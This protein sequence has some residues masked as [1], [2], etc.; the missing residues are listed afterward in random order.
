MTYFSGTREACFGR[1]AAER[2]LCS[3]TQEL[4][5]DWNQ[6]EKSGDVV[7]EPLVHQVALKCWILLNQT[8]INSASFLL[9]KN[10]SRIWVS[11]NTIEK[12]LLTSGF[13]SRGSR[14]I[15][16]TPLTETQIMQ[17]NL[18][19]LAF[20]FGKK[21]RH[22]PDEEKICRGDKTG[23]PFF[24]MNAAWTRLYKII[25]Q[26]KMKFTLMFKEA[27]I[28]RAQRILDELFKKQPWLTEQNCRKY[29]P[30]LMMAIL[31]L[32]VKASD[33][34]DNECSLINFNCLILN[35]RDSSDPSYK[36]Y[37]CITT[38]DLVRMESFLLSA[39]D[40]QVPTRIP[41]AEDIEAALFCKS[42]TANELISDL[43]LLDPGNYAIA[44]ELDH[45]ILVLR[46][47][48]NV[49]V[50]RFALAAD[51]GDI[52]FPLSTATPQQRYGDFLLF[53][54]AVCAAH[55]VENNTSPSP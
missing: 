18:E 35:R 24:E 34:D 55:Q 26:T 54:S 38:R 37:D 33:E 15:E 14:S 41:P 29:Y 48:E 46:E 42:I 17:I 27:Y 22:V 3:V 20:L 2:V 43:K 5:V 13:F 1:S 52:L 51:N 40:Y 23:V 7:S 47:T 11:S 4:E 36:Y 44:R 53:L 45:F 16:T 50:H 31:L 25:F 10:C 30:N 12:Y 39:L 9:N 8:G 32:A 6:I 28:L 19:E 49:T 21:I